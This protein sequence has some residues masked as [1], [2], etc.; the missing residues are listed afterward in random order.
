M[1]LLIPPRQPHLKEEQKRACHLFGMELEIRL[2]I[3]QK[4]YQPQKIV[5]PL[6][7]PP[8]FTLLCGRS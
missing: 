4:K 3:Q 1:G 8:S 2:R 7:R 5:E 6:D